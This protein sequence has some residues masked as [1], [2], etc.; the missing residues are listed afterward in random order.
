MNKKLQ[1]TEKLGLLEPASK[2]SLADDVVDTLL[3]AIWS[4]H[5]EAGGQLSEGEPAAQLGV[6]RGPIREDLKQLEREGL[7][8]KEANKSAVVA[9]LSGKDL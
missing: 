1:S 4:N 6:S 2:G 7:V 5:L 9:R 3:E 8:L